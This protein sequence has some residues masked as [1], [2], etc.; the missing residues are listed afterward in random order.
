R[1]AGRNP[2]RAGRENGTARFRQVLGK[3]AP[4]RGQPARAD[5][6]NAT[7]GKAPGIAPCVSYAPDH[8]PQRALRESWLFDSHQRAAA[9][10]KRRDARIPVR[11]PDAP[12]VSLLA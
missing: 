9:K 4:P 6:A 12:R 1:L 5:D 7:G 10:E 8:R 11:A 2:Q 3:D